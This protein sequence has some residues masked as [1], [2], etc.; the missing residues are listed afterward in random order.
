[1]EG[2]TIVSPETNKNDSNAI[3][4]RQVSHLRGLAVRINIAADMGTGAINHERIGTIEQR[5]AWIAQASNEL[6]DELNKF[7]PNQQVLSPAQNL[8]WITS[9]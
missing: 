1:M 8:N 3:L 9:L 2:D 4:V 6:A 5:L 7:Y